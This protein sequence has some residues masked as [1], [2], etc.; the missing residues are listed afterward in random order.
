MT[1][2]LRYYIRMGHTR[3]SNCALTPIAHA[4]ARPTSTRI[5]LPDD[6]EVYVWTR[7]ALLSGQPPSATRCVRL[8][9]FCSGNVFVFIS[10]LLVFCSILF[11]STEPVF[12]LHYAYLSV[13]FIST[14]EANSS[15]SSAAV[16]FTRPFR[17][18]ALAR[19][20]GTS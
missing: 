18:N 19:I 2:L 5:G 3:K 7:C 1:Q 11:P 4:T 13:R 15:Q 10:A 16:V 12:I 9:S 17:R 14:A 6:E 8:W 20:W